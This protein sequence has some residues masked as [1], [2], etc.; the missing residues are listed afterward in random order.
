MQYQIQIVER[1]AHIERLRLEQRRLLC[2]LTVSMIM[3]N[4]QVTIPTEYVYKQFKKAYQ[5]AS[6]E[7]AQSFYFEFPE[8]K[9]EVFTQYGKYMLEFLKG[10]FEP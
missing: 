8:G 4:E 5:K 1:I 9:R 3:T 6:K 7:G 10:K 2:A